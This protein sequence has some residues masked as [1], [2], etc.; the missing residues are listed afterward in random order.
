MKSTVYFVSA[1]I[2]R[3]SYKSSVMAKLQRALKS[4]DITKYIQPKE[5]VPLKIHFGSSGSVY[6]IRPAYVAK[7]AEEIKNINA[8]PF[9]TDTTRIPGYEYLEV[10]RR[11]G[12]DY[13]NLGIP[14]LLA[15]GIYGN[16]SVEV[17]AGPIMGKVAVA[18][19]I[20]DAPSMVVLTHFKGHIQSGVGGAIKNIAMGGV[21]YHPR[22]KSWNHGGRGK[23]HFLMDSFVP[24]WNGSPSCTACQDCV[25]ICP[26]NAISY[27]KDEIKINDSLCLRC[28]RC[29]HICPAG[30]LKIREDD[31]QFAK[32][33][34]EMAKATLST[35]KPYKVIYL[36]F[37][38]DMQ[39]ECDCMDSADVPIVPNIGILLSDDPVAIDNASL[40]LI[41][42][43]PIIKGT[44][45][46]EVVPAENQDI[47]SALHG[48]DSRAHIRLASKAGLGSLEYELKEIE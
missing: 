47:F 30:A 38:M 25:D 45:A 46:D 24:N 43:A 32:A 37:L 8:F 22:G 6:V 19:A 21:T 23:A 1:R 42:R 44:K 10:A 36:N 18:S 41:T 3:Y 27:V 15:D 39:P 28:G 4:L 9:L 17:E 20:Y 31:Q 40:D 7:V 33:L 5:V 29:S 26:M 13:P 2:N 16:D 12:Y 35:F 34:A 14:V 11:N 48:K